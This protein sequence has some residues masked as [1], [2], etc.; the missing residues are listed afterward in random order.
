MRTKWDKTF[1]AY[2]TSQ[3]TILMT[4]SLSPL[5]NRQG[6]HGADPGSVYHLPGVSPGKHSGLLSPDPCS[7]FIS[8]WWTA[9]SAPWQ[10]LRSLCNS[11]QRLWHG[12]PTRHSCFNTVLWN[13]GSGCCRIKS[14]GQ[15]PEGNLP[16]FWTQL[17]LSGCVSFLIQH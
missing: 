15:E 9:L 11:L 17:V 13:L 6:L 5:L 2:S 16:A 10:P 4:R 8:A 7:W 12:S 14:W 3:L 1:K